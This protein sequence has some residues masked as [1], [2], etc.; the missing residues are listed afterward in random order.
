MKG[1]V[2]ADGFTIVETMIV[3]AVTGIIFLSA[4]ALVNGKEAKVQFSTSIQ[5]VQQQIQQ[6][7][8]QVQSGFY[9]LSKDTFTC[10]ANAGGILIAGGT[11]SRG[12][13]SSCVFLGRALQFSNPP[14]NGSQS[15][16]A[17][18]VAGSR[19]DVT[20]ADATTI[21]QAHPTIL[22]TSLSLQT[23]SLRYGL[24]VG[25]VQIDSGSK[26]DPAVT[27]PDGVVLMSSLGS[28]SGSGDLISGAQTVD[29]YAMRGVD[30]STHQDLLSDF[31]T[32]GVTKKNPPA[33]IQICFNSGTTNQSGV[34]TIGGAAGVMNVSLKIN[35]A[36]CS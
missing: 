27:P 32:P 4:A 3:L 20:G 1:V 29:L 34:L 11:N 9:A 26:D 12:T 36:R 23:Y 22:P 24:T 25:W 33:G 16:Y 8:N 35:N 2:R 15:L 21:D 18:T 14:A 7:M 10:N 28:L 5:S 6:I 17:Y 13:N 19:T 30:F 31:N